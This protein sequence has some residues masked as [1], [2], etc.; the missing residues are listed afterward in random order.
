[1]SRSTRLA[2]SR[3]F[4]PLPKCLYCSLVVFVDKTPNDP[5]IRHTYGRFMYLAYTAVFHDHGQQPPGYITVPASTA[6][7]LQ[8]RQQAPAPNGVTAPA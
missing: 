2:L 1:M 6:V 5:F 7:I 3:C 4:Y 8:I